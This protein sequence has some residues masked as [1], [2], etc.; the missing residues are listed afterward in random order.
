M[1][2]SRTLRINYNRSKKNKKYGGKPPSIPLRNL[3][4]NI[5]SCVVHN[6]NNTILIANYG[7]NRIEV[8][9]SNR[10]HI[11]SFGEQYLYHPKFINVDPENGNIIVTNRYHNVQIFD[12]QGNF[13]RVIENVPPINFQFPP[14]EVAVASNGNIL[15][16]D[17]ENNRICITDSNGILQFNIINYGP[18]RVFDHPYGL[19]VG[20]IDGVERILVSDSHNSNIVIFELNGEF[21]RTINTL[22]EEDTTIVNIAVDDNNTIHCIPGELNDSINLYSSQGDLLRRVRLQ[23]PVSITPR[24]IR[25]DHRTGNIYL[26]DQTNNIIAVFDRNYVFL[27]YIPEIEIDAKIIYTQADIPV[28]IDDNYECGV[29]IE[30]LLQRSTIDSRKNVNG[31]IVQ[32]HENQQAQAPHMF[33][34][35]CIKPWFE[36]SRL[37]SRNVPCPMCRFVCENYSIL[38]ETNIL[39]QNDGVDFFDPPEPEHVAPA[40]LNVVENKQLLPC[41][42]YNG[43][44]K[45]CIENKPRC[46]YNLFKKQCINNSEYK[47]GK[48]KFISKQNKKNRKFCKRS[49]KKLY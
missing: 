27:H 24:V 15:L 23:A 26:T 2:I 19:C 39:E 28:G 44:Q 9:D 46:L 5:K 16:A 10:Q 7:L 41:S 32:L 29:C 13:I 35:K 25:I 4:T 48:L 6:I 30:P 37:I 3:L 22:D 8:L 1:R 40:V 18:G 17:I 14:Y 34:F 42:H 47:G 43:N 12:S 21:Y 49:F 38:T 31:Y 36:S 45:E 20:I 33:H 11:G